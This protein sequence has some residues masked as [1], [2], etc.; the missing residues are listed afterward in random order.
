MAL[1]DALDAAEKRAEETSRFVHR[2]AYARERS[3]QSV[4]LMADSFKADRDYW[5]ERAE[6]LER[7]LAQV[8]MKYDACAQTCS[9]WVDGCREDD[10]LCKGGQFDEARFAKDA[11]FHRPYR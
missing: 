2:E 8:S 3:I 10:D 1:L 9:N 5:R 7:A 4:Q 6:A 11:T